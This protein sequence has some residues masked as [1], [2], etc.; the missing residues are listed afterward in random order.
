MM[1]NQDAFFAALEDLGTN[2]FENNLRESVVI[3]LATWP[4]QRLAVFE[5]L[6]TNPRVSEAAA[7]FLPV[8]VCFREWIEGRMYEEMEL[9]DGSVPE[10]EDE[11]IIN[12]TAEGARKVEAMTRMSRYLCAD[13][14]R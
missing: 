8:D 1:S 13:A 11:W 12:L 6:R 14:R 3:F 5:D 7:R 4:H 2:L 9:D 10:N